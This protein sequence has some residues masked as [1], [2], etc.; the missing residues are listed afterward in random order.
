MQWAPAAQTALRVDAIKP[1]GSPDRSE[2]NLI[3]ADT[4][5]VV[6]SIRITASGFVMVTQTRPPPAATAMR[7]VAALDGPRRMVDTTWFVDG[8]MREM[9]GPPPLATHTALCD[10][11]IPNGRDPTLIVAVTV[12]VA[13]SMRETVSSSTC[14]T[15]TPPSPAAAS[16]HP[17][18]SAGHTLFSLSLMLAT[19]AFRPGS[20]RVSTGPVSLTA[21]TAPSPTAKAPVPAGIGT[22]ATTLPPRGI[23]W[24]RAGAFAAPR[25][26][27][28]H[29]SA[30]PATIPPLTLFIGSPPF[31]IGS[32]IAVRG[33]S[34][35][36]CRCSQLPL[37]SRDDSGICDKDDAEVVVGDLSGIAVEEVGGDQALGAI[38]AP[39]ASVDLP[40]HSAVF[41]VRVDR[42]PQLTSA[43]RPESQAV[44]AAEVNRSLLA[45]GRLV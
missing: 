14:V 8:S 43:D 10:T 38:E 24:S 45:E 5:F 21:Q 12:F 40:D 32:T 20:I 4:L 11:A 31:W 41:E 28:A 6:G 26:P 37:P 15:Q 25:S 39:F 36:R 30:A 27:T 44:A 23:A 42:G 9:L 2:E 7:S 18:A 34:R 3:V 33:A 29:A 22:F 19:T 16:P 35:S 13:G 17:G 1:H